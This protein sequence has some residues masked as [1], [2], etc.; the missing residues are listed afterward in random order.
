M[1]NINVTGSCPRRAIIRRK[2]GSTGSTTARA[3]NHV[4]SI[5]FEDCFACVA[6]SVDSRFSCQYFR[7]NMILPTHPLIVIQCG[8]SSRLYPSCDPC[9]ATVNPASSLAAV[10]A[11][12][13][14][15][16]DGAGNAPHRKGW[17]ANTKTQAVREMPIVVF[18]SKWG[19][20]SD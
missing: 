5:P 6:I 12:G 13:I 11:D 1:I 9:A 8:N 19:R 2:P 15:G 17:K 4:H 16:G 10:E 18:F 20:F 14:P 7:N 3:L